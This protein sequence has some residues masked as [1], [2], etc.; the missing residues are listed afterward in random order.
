M[1]DDLWFFVLLFVVLIG[2]ILY[3]T[4][5]QDPNRR[6]GGVYQGRELGDSGKVF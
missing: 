2:G 1:F 3:F 4:L 5:S 6:G